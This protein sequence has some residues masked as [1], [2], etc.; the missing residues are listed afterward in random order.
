MLR[1]VCLLLLIEGLLFQIP[2]AGQEQM[3]KLEPAGPPTV[4]IIGDEEDLQKRI[5][6]Q[7]RWVNLIFFGILLLVG[8]HI[9]KQYGISFHFS[10]NDMIQL[11]EQRRRMLKT[12]AQLDKQYARGEIPEEL[13]QTERQRQKQQLVEITQLCNSPLS[14]SNK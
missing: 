9:Y 11:R 3:W 1:F 13:Y 6:E 2:T 12:L 8:L 10:Q 14:T 5:K 4:D 7:L